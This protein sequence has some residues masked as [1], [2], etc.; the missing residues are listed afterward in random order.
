[1]LNAALHPAKHD[2]NVDQTDHVLVFGHDLTMYPP[3][4]TIIDVLIRSGKRIAYLGFCSDRAIVS[5]LEAQGV[6]YI[7]AI[8]NKTSD[9]PLLKLW[10]LLKYRQ[11]VSSYL[12]RAAGPRTIVWI[13]GNENLLV[14]HA[15]VPRYRS[16]LY[17]FEVSRPSVSLR[18]RIVSPTVRQ[19]RVMQHAHKVVCCEYNRAHFTKAF[20]GLKELP[21]VIPN[22]PLLEIVPGD[23]L[24]KNVRLDTSRRIILYQGILNRPERR[25]EEL[26]EAVSHL[27]AEYA[28]AIMAPE[29][30]LKRELMRKYG[31]ER[32]VFLPFI[33]PPLHLRVTREAFIGVLSYFPQPG[34][35]RSCLNTLY[36][37]PNKLYEYSRYGI[38]MLSNDIPAMREAFDKYGAGLCVQPYSPPRI[39]EAILKI[40][41]DYASFQAGASK[42]YSAVDVQTSI[43]DLI[44]EALE[45]RTMA[46][47]RGTT[48]ERTSYAGQDH[49]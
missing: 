8:V 42:L 1:V 11:I 5:E 13:F 31:S 24:P 6:R 14:L 38:P 16:I 37:A 2:A 45:D 29:N 3:I 36:C 25:L 7:E 43:C 44:G 34:D 10:K 32:V 18:Y 30:D 17:L 20:F 26:C 47:V 49:G 46:A 15:L 12:S 33:R 22:K 27:P 21:T 19:S 23:E 40:A 41:A 39:A 35:L 4:L 28:V 9:N 48:L